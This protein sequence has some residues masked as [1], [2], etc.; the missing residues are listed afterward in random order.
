MS[1]SSVETGVK[2]EIRL[3][4]TAFAVSREV[5]QGILLSIALRL[6]ITLFLVG[7]LPCAEVDIT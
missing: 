3:S 1:T 7:V 6:N 4:A 2:R 5:R